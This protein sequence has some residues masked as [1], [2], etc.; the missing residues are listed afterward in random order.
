MY[1]VKAKAKS[2]EELEGQVRDVVMPVLSILEDMGYDLTMEEWVLQAPAIWE[3]DHRHIMGAGRTTPFFWEPIR[4]AY[5]KLRG[6]TLAEPP[7]LVLGLDKQEQESLLDTQDETAKNVGR[8]LGDVVNK[9]FVN[10]AKHKN[11][12]TSS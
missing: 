2:R 10:R 7:E 4:E 9:G 8:F 3:D 11:N 1:K 6:D 5:R 12:R